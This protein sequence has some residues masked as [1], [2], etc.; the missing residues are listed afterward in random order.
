M[1]CKICKTR[2]SSSS[3]IAL[4]KRGVCTAC[5]EKSTNVSFVSWKQKPARTGTSGD[6]LPP[7]FSSV[8]R[9]VVQK[10]I[11]RMHD[12]FAGDGVDGAF[13]ARHT[14]ATGDVTMISSV[15]SSPAMTVTRFLLGYASTGSSTGA[16]LL[17]YA[18]EAITGGVGE[19]FF[20]QLGR[21][22]APAFARRGA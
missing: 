5:A 17:E 4:K 6:K 12:R 3:A 19:G 9:D 14:S 21:H 2:I 13:V 10:R 22:L 20:N 8:S 18:A 1:E 16:A 7:P 15:N 11:N